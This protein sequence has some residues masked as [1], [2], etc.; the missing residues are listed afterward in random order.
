MSLYDYQC[1]Q[2]IK[3]GKYSFDGIILAAIEKADGYHRKILTRH[4]P[5]LKNELMLRNNAIGGKLEGD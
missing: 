2:K 3:K 4:F 1:S 5:D